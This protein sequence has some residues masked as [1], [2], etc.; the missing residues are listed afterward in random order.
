MKPMF[1]AL[2]LLSAA[3]FAD[4]AAIRQ[5]LAKFGMQQIEIT[6]SPVPGLRQVVSDQGA[7]LATPDGQ[8]FLQGSL[9]QMTDKGPVDLTL[10][11]FLAKIDAQAEHAITFKAENEKHVVNVF[12]DI[13]CH[14]CKVM[15]KENQAYN[16]LGITLRYLAFPRNGLA[17][18]SA[19]QMETIWQSEDRKAA[20]TAAEAGKLPEKETRVDIVKTHYEL[21]AQIGIAGTPAMVTSGGELIGGYLPPQALLARLNGQ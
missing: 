19:R 13:T 10:R 8:F 4:D 9:V 18:Q 5:Q 15:F 3:T 14:Y 21:G 12:F 17:S 2:A 16:D 1:A 20:L 6:D 7:F 11:P